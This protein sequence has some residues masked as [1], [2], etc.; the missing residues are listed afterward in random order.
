MA[1]EFYEIVFVSGFSLIAVF[2]MT[3]REQRRKKALEAASMR[4]MLAS[5]CK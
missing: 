5:V 4:R 2:L 3:R 1:Y